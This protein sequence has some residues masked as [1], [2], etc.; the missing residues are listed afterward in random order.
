MQSVKRHSRKSPLLRLRMLS[1]AAADRANPVK[2]PL[3]KYTTDHWT[4]TLSP[5]VQDIPRRKP[6]PQAADCP[7]RQLRLINRESVACGRGCR[8]RAAGQSAGRFWYCTA[9]SRPAR[10]QRADDLSGYSRTESH[11]GQSYTPP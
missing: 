1:A 5:A 3:L 6:V 10:L 8:L 7:R 9:H 2:S 4:G 11:P